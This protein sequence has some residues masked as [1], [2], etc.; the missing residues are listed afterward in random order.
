MRLAKRYICALVLITSIFWISIDL[1]AMLWNKKLDLKVLNPE[2]SLILSIGQ[3]KR[4]LLRP[5]D[6]DGK[7]VTIEYFKQFYKPLLKADKTGL[8][9]NGA[10][11][12]NS[13]AEQEIKDKSIKDYGFNELSSSKIPLERTVPDNRE[14]G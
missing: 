8:G 3:D 6:N 7:L 4:E 1:F 11:V 2:Q 5:M 14:A 10:G 13:A 9:M 12:K